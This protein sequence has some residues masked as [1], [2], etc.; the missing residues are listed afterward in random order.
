MITIFRILLAGIVI[1]YLWEAML[2][3][4]LS[5][6][7]ISLPFNNIRELVENTDFRIAIIPGTSFEDAFKYSTDPIWQKAYEDRIQPYLDEYMEGY[8]KMIDL[9]LKDS[10]MALYDN[11]FSSR[12]VS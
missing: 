6:K 11:F 1:Y 4:Y 8:L 10:S 7:V 9:P 5:T 2:V 12:L 3:S